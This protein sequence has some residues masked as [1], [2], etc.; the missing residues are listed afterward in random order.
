LFHID[1]NGQPGIKF[2]QDLVFGHGDLAN[3]FALV[4]PEVAD[5]MAAT[6]VDELRRP[7]L[8][9]G[10]TYRDLV[11]DRSAYE[12]FDAE[13]YFGAKGFGFARLNQLALEHLMGA[14]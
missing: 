9:P 7:T 2:D 12:D 11:A 13:S 10:E 5:A 8:N 3:A 4:D 6:R 1:L 14:R